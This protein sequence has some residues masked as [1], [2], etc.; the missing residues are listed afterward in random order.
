MA[1]KF[2][3]VIAGIVAVMAALVLLPGLASQDR[4]IN[5][6]Y[7]RDNV[8]RLDNGSYEVNRREILTIAGDASARYRMDDQVDRRFFVSSDEMNVLR[9]LFLRTGF[10]QITPTAINEKSGLANYTRYQLS[11]Q[12]DDDS[13]RLMWVNPEAS[14]TSIPSIVLNAG[15]R[16]D[17]IIER[18]S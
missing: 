13:L 18:N 15:S 9:E 8:V 7:S 17:A 3:F 10:M 12:A 5:I 2:L 6:E 14:S 16:L 11:V 1:K 4:N